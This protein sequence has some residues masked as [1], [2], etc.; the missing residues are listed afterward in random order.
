MANEDKMFEMME[1]LYSEMTSRFD[2]VEQKFQKAN[3]DMQQG[4]LKVNSD[5][6][7]LENNFDTKISA[8]FDGYKQTDSKIDR[9][10]TTVNEI[11][12]KVDNQEVEIR[13]LKAVK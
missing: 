10:E 3:S 5:A 8:L 11:A 13:V 7:R 1:K 2:T 6:A 9:L 12:Q 4:F